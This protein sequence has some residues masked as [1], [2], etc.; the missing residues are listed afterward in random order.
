VGGNI[1]RNGIYTEVEGMGKGEK[2]QD[3]RKKVRNK[4]KTIRDMYRSHLYIS[5]I[6]CFIILV[7]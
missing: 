4:K 6:I 7:Q 3:R 5:R 1:K 2:R